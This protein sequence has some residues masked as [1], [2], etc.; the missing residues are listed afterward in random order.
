MRKTAAENTAFGC[1]NAMQQ[2]PRTNTAPYATRSLLEASR[3]QT[4]AKHATRTGTSANAAVFGYRG[5]TSTR[6]QGNAPTATTPSAPIKAI[7]R[8]PE[9]RTFMRNAMP[10]GK[11]IAANRKFTALT[12]NATSTPKALTTMEH[13]ICHPEG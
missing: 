10:K 6:T 13:T 2:Q 5:H 9:N 11:T 12:A 7:A 3:P 1:M 8:S 4:A